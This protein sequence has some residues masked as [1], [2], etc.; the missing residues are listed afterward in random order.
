MAG[1]KEATLRRWARG[2]FYPLSQNEQPNALERLR[3]EMRSAPS[4]WWRAF[5]VVFNESDDDAVTNLN[6][7]LAALLDAGADELRETVAETAR[8]DR[9]FTSSY[10]EAMHDLR[11]EAEAYRQLGRSRTIEAFVRHAPR[12]PTSADGWSAD[13]IFWLVEVQPDEAWALGL[14]LLEAS[15]EDDWLNTI[16]AFVFEELLSQHGDAIIDRIEKE[17]PKNERLRRALPSARWCTPDHLL[18][19]VKAASGEYWD[20]K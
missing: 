7:P 10:W 3:D 2:E 8:I 13:V 16:G 20:R 6:M 9:S 19:R 12:I 1:H 17:A 18:R 14:E 4:E 15:A 11:R 5:Q